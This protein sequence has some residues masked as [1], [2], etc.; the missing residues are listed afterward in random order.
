M[1]RGNMS[2][3]HVVVDFEDF[4]ELLGPLLPDGP[5]A[6]FHLRDV[7]LGNARHL[8]KLDLR[9]PFFCPRPSKRDTRQLRIR[10]GREAFSP[11]DSIPC[12]LELQGM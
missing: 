2:K 5:L 8:G 7:A 9:Y 10:L 3:E 4:C 11:G 6:V 1:W 12:F